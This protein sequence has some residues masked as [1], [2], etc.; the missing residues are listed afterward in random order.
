[1]A[2]APR[3]PTAASP[4]L[5]KLCAL[6]AKLAR[7]HG[8]GTVGLAGAHANGTAEAHDAIELF[9]IVPLESAEAFAHALA[10][11]TGRAINLYDFHLVPW[12]HPF[13]LCV[14]WLNV[15]E[16]PM[17]ECPRGAVTRWKLTRHGRT[18]EEAVRL[19]LL[20]HFRG[21]DTFIAQRTGEVVRVIGA[22]PL[23]GFHGSN[24]SVPGFAH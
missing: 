12:A 23:G 8:L 5:A 13:H 10:E 16:L 2:T 9:M 24:R 17:R 22:P 14:R 3:Q 11:K 1:M 4:A 15:V 6:I 18:F 7:E 19:D 20:P 21:V